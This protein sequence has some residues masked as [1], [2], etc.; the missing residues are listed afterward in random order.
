MAKTIAVTA[1]NTFFMIYYL[2]I[3]DVI[4]IRDLI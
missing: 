3:A 2:L 4:L 1:T